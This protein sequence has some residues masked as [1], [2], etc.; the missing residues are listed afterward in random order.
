M[1]HGRL[2][3]SCMVVASDGADAPLDPEMP[4]TLSQNEAWPRVMKMDHVLV[5]STWVP[6]WAKTAADRALGLDGAG[7]SAW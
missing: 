7:I 6:V 3:V 2:I 4:T 5:P 1:E